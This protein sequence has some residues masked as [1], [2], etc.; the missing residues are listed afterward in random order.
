[1]QAKEVSCTE[2]W[3]TSQAKEKLKEQNLDVDYQLL[4]V[5]IAETVEEL[6]DYVRER[7]GR[8]DVLINNA[9]TALLLQKIKQRGI[10]VG[11][12]L[13]QTSLEE[14]TEQIQHVFN[15]NTLG[16]AK[17]FV[18]SL[19]GTLRCMQVFIPLMREN[20]F[21]RIVNITSALGKL[22]N[23]SGTSSISYCISKVCVD[24]VANL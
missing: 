9:G 6:A 5:G 3:L 1:V 16:R 15:V 24:R 17:V 7:Y 23:Q 21:G 20:N 11:R 19:P 2:R 8:L 4:D 12:P 14:S 18:S 10:F 13:G 22:E